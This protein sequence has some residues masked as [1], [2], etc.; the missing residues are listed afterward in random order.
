MWSSSR[1]TFTT[2]AVERRLVELLAGVRVD[3]VLSDMA[4]NLS[5]IAAADAARS[6]H[7]AEIA[8]DFA[9]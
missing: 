5:G 4:P 9:G 2:E 1:A 3:L 8:A 6:L 7:L